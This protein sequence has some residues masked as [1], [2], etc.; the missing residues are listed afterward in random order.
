MTNFTP[1][2]FAQD[3]SNTKVVVADRYVPHA[4]YVANKAIIESL[5]G[6]ILKGVGGF[7]A[8]FTKVADAKAFIKQAITSVSEEEYNSTR[9]PK[10]ANEESKPMDKGNEPPKTDGKGS[11]KSKARKGKGNDAPS[12]A[13][14]EAS[15]KVKESKGKG[16]APELTPSA[17]KALDKMKMSVLNRAA[18]AYSIANGGVAT[19]F[20]ALGKSVDDLKD[21]IP[22][23]KEGF[24]KSPKWAPKWEKAVETYGLTEDMLG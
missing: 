11:K 19:T 24:L 1:I 15:T 16:N 17:Q 9:K 14:A 2:T 4:L 5:G 23:A 21:F 13:V 12:K 20:S 3:K 18:S 8:E 6:T 22:K 7:K 10:P